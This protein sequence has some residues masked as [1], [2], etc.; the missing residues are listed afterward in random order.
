MGLGQ[1][2]GSL[3]GW[4]PRLPKVRVVPDLRS[5]TK[6]HGNAEG[7]LPGH[8]GREHRDDGLRPASTETSDPAEGSGSFHP[9]ETLRG[10]NTDV[11]TCA[12]SH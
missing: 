3:R 11:V 6:G 4:K 5:L 12:A 7:D 9:E 1:S 8:R 2:L 10:A